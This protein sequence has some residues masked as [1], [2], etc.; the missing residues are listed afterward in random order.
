MQLLANCGKTHILRLN[1]HDIVKALIMRAIT[2]GTN[3]GLRVLRVW[4]KSAVTH[5][6]KT[7]IYY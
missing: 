6:K 4:V 3:L 2:A 7:V 5:R 1:P